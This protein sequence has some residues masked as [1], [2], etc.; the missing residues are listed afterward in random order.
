LDVELSGVTRA[1]AAKPV[2]RG[3][4]LSLAR[5]RTFALLGPNGAGKTTLLRILATLTRPDA[6]RVRIAGLDALREGD[7]VRRNTGYV[8]HQPYLYDEL[9]ARENLVFFARMYGVAEPAKRAAALLERVGLAARA[10]DRARTLSRGQQQRLALARGTLHEP[11]VL[12]LDEP[13]T[14]LDEQA[15]AL[16][17]DLLAERTAAGQTTL[18]TTHNLERALALADEVVIL[19][20]GRIV[21]SAETAD[22]DLASLRQAYQ[23]QT[24]PRR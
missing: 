5:G 3:V 22:T 17:A 8:G 10:G 19:A 2:L 13:D 15:G 6:G 23:Q 9:T 21:Y 14:G 11:R 1:Y 12:L 20:R 18:L 4:N 24:E 16:L 7:A